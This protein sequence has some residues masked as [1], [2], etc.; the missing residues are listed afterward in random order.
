VFGGV[1]CFL[2]VEDA[3]E[4]GDLQQAGDFLVHI[5][6]LDLA[7]MFFHLSI[8]DQE[9]AESA[10]VAEVNIRKVDNEAFKLWFA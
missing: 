5:D 10:A 8:G 9:G 6:Q 2:D 1:T 4:H 3:V 7:A